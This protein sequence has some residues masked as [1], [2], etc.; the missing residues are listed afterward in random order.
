MDSRRRKDD[1]NLS[2]KSKAK[3]E[4]VSGP[5]AKSSQFSAQPNVPLY[6]PQ[7]NNGK[8][9]PHAGQA[10]YLAIRNLNLMSQTRNNIFRI[11]EGIDSPEVANSI[12][13]LPF[14]QPQ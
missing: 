4:R 5:A 9:V 7:M 10:L 8:A 12:L 6:P 11:I 2:R 13:P 3:K 14:H 1:H